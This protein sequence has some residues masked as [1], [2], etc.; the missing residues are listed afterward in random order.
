MGLT[1]DKKLVVGL[2]LGFGLL[3]Y[4]SYRTKLPQVSTKVEP[5]KEESHPT[6]QASAPVTVVVEEATTTEATSEAPA[7]ERMEAGISRS[8]KTPE[9][10]SNPEKGGWRAL[11]FINSMHMSA[12]CYFMNLCVSWSHSPK[13]ED[14]MISYWVQAVASWTMLSLY[15]WTLIAPAVCKSRQF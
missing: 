3:T 15:A 7:Q 4:A 9:K 1:S 10:E 2:S 14:N 6:P 8:N 12:A 5:T 11:L 13:G